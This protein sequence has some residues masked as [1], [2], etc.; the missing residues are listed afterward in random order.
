MTKFK[1]VKHGSNAVLG[2]FLVGATV[3]LP[4]VAYARIVVPATACQRAT[5]SA[6]PASAIEYS[7]TGAVYNRSE[8]Q[9][10]TVVCPVPRSNTSTH[11]NWFRVYGRDNHFQPGTN[12]SLGCRVRS[13]NRW[14]N[15]SV[16]SEAISTSSVAAGVS[17]YSPYFHN[18]DSADENGSYTVT[19]YIPPIEPTSNQKSFIGSIVIDEPN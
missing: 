3:V 8:T 7:L 4:E 18:V 1:N 10:L 12:G 19:C 6:A 15:D 2:L 16:D 9:R 14:G 17:D 11:P 5:A 13:N